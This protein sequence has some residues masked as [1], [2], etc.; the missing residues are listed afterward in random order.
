MSVCVQLSACL[1]V[2][3]D[4]GTTLSIVTMAHQD[5]LAAAGRQNRISVFNKVTQVLSEDVGGGVIMGVL[6]CHIGKTHSEHTR[7]LMEGWAVVLVNVSV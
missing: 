4:S 7:L 6:C 2:Y 1:L 3:H 5:L